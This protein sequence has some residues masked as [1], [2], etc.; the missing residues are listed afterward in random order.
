MNKILLCVTGSIAAYKALELTRL[1]VKAGCDVKVVLSRSALEFVTPLSFEA[2]CKQKS[3]Q[4]LFEYSETPIEH[5][6]LAR[7]AD[8]IL[9]APATAN[10][11]A[12][13][14]YGIADDLLG[15]IILATKK[16]IYVAPAMNKQMWHNSIVKENVAR[17]V[18]R[19]FTL[20]AP[21]TGEQACG[22]IG[23]GRLMEPELIAKMVL[24]NISKI[25][26]TVVITAGPTVEA[27]DP[28]RYL[29]NYSSGK[30]GYA[31]ADAFYNLGWRVVLISGPTELSA[32]YGIHT[33][34]VKSAKEMYDAVH[35]YVDKAELFIGAAAVA[36][37]R[38]QSYATHKIKK[39]NDVD[40][41]LI[42][43]LS[44]NEDIVK[45]VANLQKNR[46]LCV[47]GFAAETDNAKVYALQKISAKNLDYLVL[48]QVDNK[49]GF[50]FYSDQNQVQIY[51]RKGRL[52]LELTLMSKLDVAYQI[53]HM[54][55]NRLAKK[56]EEVELNY[57]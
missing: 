56:E 42:L 2:L 9:I 26:K 13:L 47:V 46:P 29:S 5:I 4:D 27:L 28:V 44:K 41:E 34:Y 54:L 22:E 15:N 43:K 10:T 3:Y 55:C 48:N 50:P 16:P 24:Q 52:V 38:P 7:W 12:K 31:L 19:Q 37:Y 39:M 51:D 18:A 45:S 40:D 33:I 25:D 1:L 35:E 32:S 6:E 20:L 17:L 11:L 21:D 49:T 57:G 30:M 8:K 53:A 14:A 23:E 36:D